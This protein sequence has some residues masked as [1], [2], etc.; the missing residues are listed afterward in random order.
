[1]RPSDQPLPG[2]L[3]DE[4]PDGNAMH[5]RPGRS[6]GRAWL[7]RLDPRTQLERLGLLVVALMLWNSAVERGWVESIYA[8]TPGQT[9]SSLV[10]FLGDDLFW[11]DLAVTLGEALSGWAIG[12]TT[13][14]F[15]GLLLGRWRHARKVL[16]PYLTFVNAIPKI[17]LAPIIILWFGIG[18]SSKVALA[19]MVVFFIVQVP[20]T[21]AVALT[22]PDL[23]TVATTL[24]A[25]EVQKFFKVYLPGILAAVFGALR[26]GAVYA[27]LAV[28]FGEFLAAREGLGQRLIAATNQFNM[29]DAFALMIVLAFLALTIN[30]GIGLLERH[31]LR[32]QESAAHGSVVSL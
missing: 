11:T 26:L 6:L 28:V 3:D 14:L 20:T 2:T 15:A 7:A 1:M 30:G 16:G 24:G 10:D 22:N 31:L 21:S 19:A 8:A 12:A 32:W 18:M 29:A 23:D 5:D 9:V 17:A 4:Q 13:G 27:L 25:T